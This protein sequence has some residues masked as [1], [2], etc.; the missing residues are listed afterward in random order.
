MD[1]TDPEGYEEICRRQRSR[2]RQDMA[3]DFCAARGAARSRAATSARH[4][5]IEF[6]DYA[7]AL[8]C[9][10]N[11]GIVAGRSVVARRRQRRVR[12]GCGRRLRRSAARLTGREGEVDGRH[13]ACCTGAAG[14]M[15]R[16][17]VKTISRAPGV[18]LSGALEREGS[19]ALG[20]D[21]GLL[22]GC[23]NAGVAISSDPL[24]A[25]LKADGII[26]FS[27]AGGERGICACCARGAG[28][29]RSCRRHHWPVE[30][31]YREDRRRRASCDDRAVRQYEPWGQSF[32][33]L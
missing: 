11:R 26:D 19:L 32:G 27:F 9:Y 29:Y 12:R 8:A 21:A 30:R 15:G 31:R 5:V 3:D 2:F 25:V 4:V 18:V 23:G 16:M 22:A 13:A 1:V 7:T 14:R 24:A 20:E 17:L 6:K 28:A 33:S 10:G